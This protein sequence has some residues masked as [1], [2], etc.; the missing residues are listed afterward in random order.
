MV[1]VEN[2]MSYDFDDP[3][4]VELCDCPEHYVE[5]VEDIEIEHVKRD[6]Y[7]IVKRF[8][9]LNCEMGWTKRTYVVGKGDN[10]QIWQEPRSEEE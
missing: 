8:I 10:W 9:C 5:L 4:F 3:P 2:I 1:K 6:Y 7:W